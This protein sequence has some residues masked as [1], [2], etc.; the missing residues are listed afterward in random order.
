MIKGASEHGINWFQ[1]VKFGMF[2]HWGLYSLLGR[3]EWVMHWEAIPVQEYEKLR[4]RF[5]PV[6]FKADEWVQLAADA[7]QKY[8]VITSRHHDGFSMYDT[9]LSDYKITNTGFK[10]DPIAE[11]AEACIKNKQVKL[12]FYVSLLDWHHPAYRFRQESGLAW[13]DYLGFLHGQVEELCLNYGDLACFWFDG[14]WPRHH[15]TDENAYFLAGGSF[16]YD[17]L[18][19]IIRKLQPDAIIH[20]NRHE[21]PLPGEDV[22]GFEQD[23]PGANTAGFNTTEIYD[24]PVEVC[25]TINDNWGIHFEDENHKSTRQLIHNLVR[26]ASVNGNFL[27]NVGPT[28]GGKI[29]PEHTKRL[30]EV[31]MWLKVNGSSIYGTRAGVIPATRDTVST[32]KIHPDQSQG[33]ST[34]FVHV[35]EY[36]SDCVVL[37]GVPET[38]MDATLLR[39]GTPIKTER[40]GE[41]TILTITPD[42]RDPIDTVVVL[43]ET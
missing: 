11:L 17:K 35:L 8:M 33:G 2:I 4:S 13:E 26:S 40:R 24:L 20:N 39:D 29:L 25:M 1:D 7:G 23:L 16:E 41:E 37:Q 21:K 9:A 30:R 32:Y 3:G 22:Q 36:R 19:G 6:D 5:N 28:A 34:H 43:A 12:G 15:I 14:D 10:R 42:L 27:L 31:G 18:Y 38:V